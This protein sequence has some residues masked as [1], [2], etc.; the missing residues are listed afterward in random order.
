MTIKSLSIIIP[1][2]NEGDKLID[3]LS[4][5]KKFISFSFA[6]IDLDFEIIIVNDGSK[7]N[8]KNIIESY[9]KTDSCCRFVTYDTNRGKGFAVKE[10]IKK[11]TKDIVVFMDAD[12]STDLSALI[13]VYEKIY[14]YD[15]VIGSRRHHQSVLVAPQGKRR[16]IIGK[17]CSLL[18]NI[19]MSFNISDTQCGFK[20]F[21]GDIA[22]NLVLS[23]TVDG[24]AFDVEL[25]YMAYINN[26]SITEI[27]VI[28]ENDEDS[29]VKL[30]NSSFQFIKDLLY[31]KLRKN[32]YKKEEA[33]V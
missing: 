15:I 24:F 7:D 11:S 14:E 13:D 19:I 25:L 22:R 31:I 23:Q 28:W 17:A 9:C 18:T 30:I 6:D 2:Y 21:K 5:I 3:N 12:L 20:A 29:K 26:Y 10:G 32:N 1:C 8:S 4:K 33:V 27:P 16:R